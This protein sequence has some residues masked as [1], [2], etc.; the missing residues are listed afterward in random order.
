MVAK[1][2]VIGAG[3]W[4]QG[5]HIPC[6]DRNPNAQLVAI[7]DRSEHP[8][9]DLAPNLVSL[10]TLGE[11]YNTKVYHS[12]QDMLEQ[13]GDQL[14]GVIICTP[15]STHYQIGKE[16]YEY[17][18][19]NN[20][21]NNK[22]KTKQQEK[23][24]R[25]IHILMEK[26]MATDVDHAKALFELVQS[27][28][29]TSF[30]VNHSAN[31]RHQARVARDAVITN[32]LIGKIRHITCSMAS[33]LMWLF[34]NPNNHVWNK[35]SGTMLGNGFAWAQSCHLLGW[36]YFVCGDLANPI[37]VFCAMNHEPTTGADMSHSATILCEDD[38]ILNVSGTALLPGSQFAKT[39]IGK[40]VRVQIYGTKG[41]IVYEGD[42]NE[43]LSGRLEWRK[44]DGSIEV[45]TQ[46][47]LFENSSAEGYGAE[48]VVNFVQLCCCNNNRDEARAAAPPPPPL[49]MNC[50]DVWVGLR[51]VQTLEAM[52][53]SHT[54]KA[55]V[56]VR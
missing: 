5:W 6:L 49:P 30:W 23:G 56:E 14:D 29:E 31:F 52:Y 39:Q 3:W 9:S 25:P 44:K 26:P 45:L 21:N 40:Q 46:D 48:S 10:S 43:P 12:V 18:N 33:P 11:Q 42:D 55:M 51:T 34:Q 24:D 17:N 36:I 8:Q 35:P 53:R 27:N 22:I 32:Q 19:N 20:N 50:A 1:I 4:S 13:M 54:L 38:I 15:H 2:A 28:P 16:I 47:F 41:A 37:K 7:V